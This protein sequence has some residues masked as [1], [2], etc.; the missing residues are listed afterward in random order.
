M[1]K[2]S[3]DHATSSKYD[4][5]RDRKSHISGLESSRGKKIRSVFLK[6]NSRNQK[7]LEI[8]KT[9][10]SWDR[11]SGRCFL[12]MVFTARVCRCSHSGYWNKYVVM[13]FFVIIT[14]INYLRK[15]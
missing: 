13:V 11:E 9:L 2:Q 10:N 8:R 6:M 12:P 5:I 7:T 1:K 3:Q 4:W 15:L 14:N